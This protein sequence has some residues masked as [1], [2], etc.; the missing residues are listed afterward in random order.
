MK[1]DNILIDWGLDK[2]G[3][4]EIERVALA[5]LDC[6]LKMKGNQLLRLPGA[7]RIGN[8]MWRSPEGHAGMG[9]GKPSDLFSYGLVV[10]EYCS[11]LQED[12]LAKGPPLSSA[13]TQSRGWKRYE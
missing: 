2:Q 9:I 10:S 5:D 11:S 4:V 13:S 3:Q 7:Q 8:F 12:F 6:S 1:P